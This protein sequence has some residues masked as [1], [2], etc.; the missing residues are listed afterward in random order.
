MEHYIRYVREL[1][2][3]WGFVY[4]HHFAPHDI[5]HADWSTGEKRIHRAQRLGFKFV[6]VPRPAAKRD[7]IEYTRA[8]FKHYYIHDKNCSLAVDALMQYHAKEN[9][10]TGAKGGPHHDWSSNAADAFMLVA[11]AH[12]AGLMPQQGI[13]NQNLGQ[14]MNPYALE[15]VI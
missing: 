2:E 6:A 5:C 1:G 10:S 12:H 14:R 13:G 9:L 15:S 7:Q 8:L 4:A 11:E 3:K